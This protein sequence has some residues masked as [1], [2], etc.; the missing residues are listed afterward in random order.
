MSDS[1]TRFDSIR[2]FFDVEN[3]QILFWTGDH[4][5]YMVYQNEG[6]IYIRELGKDPLKY[7]APKR[8]KDNIE[9]WLYD[10]N[11]AIDIEGTTGVEYDRKK[12]EMFELM[13]KNG[14]A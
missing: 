13:R 4:D 9:V 6:M 5:K 7:T 10:P 1:M 2:V 8:L 12:K 3:K 11:I 14:H